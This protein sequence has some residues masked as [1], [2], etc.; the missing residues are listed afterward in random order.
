MDRSVNLFAIPPPLL[1]GFFR[2]CKLTET[3][4]KLAGDLVL[5]ID[6]LRSIGYAPVT[7]TSE[8]LAAMICTRP[9]SAAEQVI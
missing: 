1:L 3:W 6:K 5:S 9:R 4:E 2:M 7:T 8:G